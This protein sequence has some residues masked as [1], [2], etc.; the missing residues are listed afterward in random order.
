VKLIREAN[1][2]FGKSMYVSRECF[3]QRLREKTSGFC[4][5]CVNAVQEH[6]RNTYLSCE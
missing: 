2:G 6:Y 5:R 4:S 3:E 1:A